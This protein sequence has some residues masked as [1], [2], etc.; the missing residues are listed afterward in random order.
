MSSPAKRGQ[1]IMSATAASGKQT[2]IET[3]NARR[4]VWLDLPLE[5]REVVCD[6]S[7]QHH[8]RAHATLVLRTLCKDSRD[9]VNAAIDGVWKEYDELQHD[10]CVDVRMQTPSHRNAV[11][12]RKEDNE[13]LAQKDERT[14]EAI[15]A[16]G[17]L[18]RR[19]FGKSLGQIGMWLA[20]RDV[21]SFLSAL[22]RCC[23]F[24]RRTMS[25]GDLRPS[26]LGRHVSMQAER[27]TRL[28]AQCSLGVLCHEQCCKPMV[29]KLPW[30]SGFNPNATGHGPSGR[31]ATMM[32]ALSYHDEKDDDGQVFFVKREDLGW[33]ADFDNA[34][35]TLTVRAKAWRHVVMEC[36]RSEV[37]PHFTN[38]GW[39]AGRG[40]CVMLD[41]HVGVS[42]RECGLGILGMKCKE[43][44]NDLVVKA[45]K[46]RQWKE[47]Q[48]AADKSLTRDRRG[49]R[50]RQKQRALNNW[51]KKKSNWK[52]LRQLQAEHPAAVGVLRIDDLHS[53]SIS[54]VKRAIEA[55]EDVMRPRPFVTSIPLPPHVVETACLW[56]QGIQATMYEVLQSKAACQ[57][58]VP[59]VPGTRSEGSGYPYAMARFSLLGL[60]MAPLLLQP[61]RCSSS[62]A[63]FER[64]N[65]FCSPQMF[66]TAVSAIDRV[67]VRLM[68]WLL[69]VPQFGLG[70]SLQEVLEGS[71]DADEVEDGHLRWNVSMATLVFESSRSTVMRIPALHEPLFPALQFVEVSNFS[72]WPMRPCRNNEPLGK[73]TAPLPLHMETSVNKMR[74]F[75]Q[76]VLESDEASNR[77][78]E[79]CRELL[80]L[81]RRLAANV[82]GLAPDPVQAN[83]D[84][85]M[86]E[87][88]AQK[89]ARL[90]RMTPA[91]QHELVELVGD[92]WRESLRL[93]MGKSTARRHAMSPRDLVSQAC[94]FSFPAMAEAFG[95]TAQLA[96]PCAR[97]SVHHNGRVAHNVGPYSHGWCLNNSLAP[98]N[99]AA[100]VTGCRVPLGAL[101]AAMA[102]GALRPSPLT[103]CNEELAVSKDRIE[104]YVDLTQPTG[105]GPPDPLVLDQQDD[106]EP[107][108]PWMD[109]ED[110][111]NNSMDEESD[112]DASDDEDPGAVQAE[113]V[114]GM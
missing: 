29:C 94:A 57:S 113:D 22:T 98:A 26:G 58:G 15:N 35:D 80:E 61:V 79:L 11:S 111:D 59:C 77:E 42:W 93:L 107:I 75:A 69:P 110:M 63:W 92:M 88:L 37:H 78:R 21:P 50:M 62:A 104:K 67:P 48:R 41:Q 19:V 72:R 87:T 56:S 47:S 40:Q 3:S 28:D 114:W 55:F 83:P 33:H 14:Q 9:L 109:D 44:E 103:R 13:V 85:P 51:M 20:G 4:I 60:T 96:A 5:L 24:C 27:L 6:F 38:S 89:D 17:A 46:V 102:L 73:E 8:S 32:L 1:K 52:S 76:E 53:E 43:D 31:L 100:V 64:P 30:Q 99:A 36:A 74:R 25:A 70:L 10:S 65:S 34:I 71:A 16:L 23:A 82:R 2:R 101:C 112:L 66:E 12:L 97:Q 68:V 39:S 108:H 18:S 7:V 54:D 49:D 84:P 45:A 95:F 105:R 86:P 81:C 106:E 90:R 91:L